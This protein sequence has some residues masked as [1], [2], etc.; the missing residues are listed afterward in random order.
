VEGGYT[1]NAWVRVTHPDYDERR[2]ILTAIGE[3]VMVR[4]G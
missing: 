2:A 3:T 4:A 1:V